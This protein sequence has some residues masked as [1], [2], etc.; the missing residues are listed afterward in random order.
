MNFIFA[1]TPDFAARVLRELEESGRRPILV[2]SQPD[3]P[4]GRG[5][6][7]CCPPTVLEARRLG[8][9]AVQ[10]DDLNAPETIEC[11]AATGAATLVVAAFGQILRAQVLE[12]FLCLNIHASLLPAYRGAA[13][14]ERAIAAGEEKTG[15]SIMRVTEPLDEGPWALQT[16]LTMSLR[17]DAGSVARALAVLGALGIDQ[18]LTGLSDGTVSWHDQQGAA[19]YAHKLTGEDTVFDTRVGARAVHDRVR[20][21]S[22]CVGVRTCSGAVEFKVW[23]TWP[24][25]MPRLDALPEQAAGLAGMPGRLLATG[26]RLF[27]GCSEGAVELLL[28]QPA[29][30]GRMATADFLRGYGGRLGA[31]LEPSVAEDPSTSARPS[32]QQDAGCANR[33]EA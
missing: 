3:R 20:A 23:R 26:G 30:K 17:D 27:A 28:V 11:M 16:E 22:P 25:G 13:P 33:E 1:G 9:D 29:G 7:S 12:R 31:C 2:V 21:L 6:R 18:V 8:I 15:V 24:Y 4:Q 19:N 14:I 5:R 32:A 10:V